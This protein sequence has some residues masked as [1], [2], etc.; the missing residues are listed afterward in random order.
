MVMAVLLEAIYGQDVR[1]LREAVL[2]YLRLKGFVLFLFDNLDRFWTPGGFT[3]DD[4]MIVVGLTESMQEIARKF[5]RKNLDF[6]W[7]I[8]VRSGVHEFLIRGMADY[9][10]LAVQSLEW[11]VGLS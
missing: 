4:A 9:G 1:M 2:E 3:D 10:K 5:R 6:R 7:G 11:T 8:F